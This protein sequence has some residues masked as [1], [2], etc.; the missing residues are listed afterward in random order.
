[1]RD[2][3][4][5]CSQARTCSALRFS[6]AKCAGICLRPSLRSG[7]RES[8]SVYL[9]P[10]QTYYRHTPARFFVTITEYSSGSFLRKSKLLESSFTLVISSHIALVYTITQFGVS[11]AREPYRRGGEATREHR[12][13]ATPL[14]IAFASRTTPL[15]V[16]LSVS[17]P[18]V[19]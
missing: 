18:H 8:N 16:R 3:G 10:K 2:P 11:T 6:T 13:P 9:L 17:L 12:R 5:P 19:G 7:R 15:S 1:M 14:P 4:S